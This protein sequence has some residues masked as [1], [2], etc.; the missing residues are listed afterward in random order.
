M[1]VL[2]KANFVGTVF[3]GG[4]KEQL[5]QDWIWGYCCIYWIISRFKNTQEVLR[6]V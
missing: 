5:K 3:I 1:T 4:V 6:T 2:E